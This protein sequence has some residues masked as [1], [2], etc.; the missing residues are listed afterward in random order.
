MADTIAVMNDGPHRAD[1]RARP[2]STSRPTTTFV[3]NFLGQSNLIAGRGRRH[4]TATT[5][6]S[7]WAAQKL[8]MPAAR[9]PSGG[10]DLLIG[11]RP[12]KIRLVPAGE[13]DT[14]TGRNV[15][16]GG[17]V[18]DASFTGVSTQY[19][20]RM[21]WG[22]EL[23]VFAQNLGAAACCAPARTVDLH[24]D[25]A[26]TFALDG[27]WTPTP[28]SSS[29]TAPHPSRWADDE[30]GTGHRPRRQQQSEDRRTTRGRRA[31][32]G[33]AGAGRALP[34]AAARACC[35]W[36]SSSS[37]RS[38]RCCSTSPQTRPPGAEIGVYT[39]TFR[40]ANY[41]DTL[42]EY[43]RVSS[44][45]SPTPSSPP[46]WRSRSPT[47]WPTHRVQGRA[48][49]ATCC[50]CW[51]SRRSSPASCCARVAWKQILADDG[52]GRRLLHFLHILLPRT[53]GS[54]TRR[55]RRHRHHVQLPAVHDPADLRLARAG[56][57]A[58][59]SRRPATCTPTRSRRSAR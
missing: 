42:N 54:S 31:G 33:P 52:V 35:G 26:H 46:S 48:A 14:A 23:M 32:R 21:P 11:V 50:W 37:S 38:S 16:P 10:D 4:A 25:P 15:L 51:W 1:G 39:Q 53:A 24:W 45:R 19:L 27:A 28:A 55:R 6:C 7:R 9:R 20:V 57:P 41:T 12:E 58:P 8:A 47:R 40:L 36:R 44:G 59:A 49:G 29:T 18:T 17:V 56:R 2:S 43:C 13:D 5:W 34:A 30:R 3:A 22:Q